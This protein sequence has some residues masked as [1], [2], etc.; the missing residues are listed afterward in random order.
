MGFVG[1][2]HDIEEILGRGKEFAS[3]GTDDEDLKRD[4]PSV[5]ALSD[6]IA[7][8]S[9]TGRDRPRGIARQG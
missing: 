8:G 6:P 3:E 4:G 5:G 9:R 2:K 1:S 7:H